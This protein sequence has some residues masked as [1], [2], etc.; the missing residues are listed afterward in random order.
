MK[1]YTKKNLDAMVSFVIA[2]FV[3]ASSQL[4]ETITQISSQ[5]VILLLLSVFFL[6]LV[7]SFAQ[8]TEG[9]FFLPGK[10]NATFMEYFMKRL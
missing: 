2:F 3:I 8:E 6:I 10:L 9:G 5:V 4:V 1:K 7:G